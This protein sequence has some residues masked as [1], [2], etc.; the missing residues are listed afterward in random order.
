MRD[1]LRLEKGYWVNEK[2]VR[3]LLRLMGLE[4]VAPKLDLSKPANGHRVYPTC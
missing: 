2:R 1:F 4:A 3:R